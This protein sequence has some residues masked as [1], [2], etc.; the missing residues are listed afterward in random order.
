M[1]NQFE[2]RAIYEFDEKGRP[3]EFLDQVTESFVKV[4]NKY[5]RDILERASEHID[6][7]RLKQFQMRE[8]RTGKVVLAVNFRPGMK[9]IYRCRTL[10]HTFIITGKG[11]KTELD[12]L[13]KSLPP[14]TEKIWIV[15]WHMT[16][17]P[18]RPP[19]VTRDDKDAINIQIVFAL[20]ED[21]H[22][23]VFDKWQDREP[24][25]IPLLKEVEK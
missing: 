1:R 7:D 22:I 24:Y 18:Q 20:H 2:W 11:T 13:M 14:Q 25:T 16:R 21:G 8:V 17:Y 5:E 3:K 10:L 12:Q 4:G 19:D 23:E 6:R 15:G 9:L